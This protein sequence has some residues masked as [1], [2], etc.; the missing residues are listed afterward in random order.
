MRIKI[1]FEP[2]NDVVKLS[3]NYNHI[4]Q[5]IIYLHIDKAIAK[6]VHDGGFQLGKRVYKMFTFSRLRADH[7]HFDNSIKKLVLTGKI[8]FYIGS[9]NMELLESFALSMVREETLELG[10]DQ[11][12][13]VSAVE[14]ETPVEPVRPAVIKMMSPLTVYSTLSTPDGRK[15]TYYYTPKEEEFSRLIMEN[16]QRKMKAYVGEKEDIPPLE[17]AYI[18]PLK[19]TKHDL[20][21]TRFKN[22]IIKGWKGVYELSLPPPYFE[23]AYNT[24]LGSKNSQGFGMFRVLK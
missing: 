5:G 6:K 4:L 22:F 14:V 21:I 16:L 13:R 19:V 2:V 11:P 7:L 23:L 3:P 9:L 12:V 17:N 24:G 18:K 10:D 1:T 20:I 8:W 15:K